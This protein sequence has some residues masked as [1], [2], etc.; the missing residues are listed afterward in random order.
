[1]PPALDAERRVL[2]LAVCL[3]M[4]LPSVLGAAVEA[5]PSAPEVQAQPWAERVVVWVQPWGRPEVGLREVP[6]VGLAVQPLVLR[7]EAVRPDEQVAR[8]PSVQQPEAQRAAEERLS[9][10]QEG[11]PWVAPSVRPSDHQE[12]VLPLV[13]R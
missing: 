4:A 9:V 6:Q 10:L 12:P 3:W 7:A 2:S 11:R 1:M 8:V 5:P 13:Q